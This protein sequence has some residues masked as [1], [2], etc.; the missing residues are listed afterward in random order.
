MRCAGGWSRRRRPRSGCRSGSCRFPRR[1]RTTSTSARWPPSSRRA[2]VEGYEEMAFGDLF[3][4]DIRQYRES[5]LAGTG[6]APRFPLFGADTTAL[7]REMIAG[8]PEGAAHLRRSARARP[9][10]SPDAISTPRCW[11]ICRRRS[12]RAASAANSIRSPTPVRCSRRRLRSK[13]AR[14][15][16]ATASSSPISHDASSQSGQL[17]NPVNDNQITR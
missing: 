8:R 3:L 11:P 5:R 14:S 15:S 13:P 1:A 16:S 10:L 7:A 2:V 17:R 12:I 4:E 9:A 6:L